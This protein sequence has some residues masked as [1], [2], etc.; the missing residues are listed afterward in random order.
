MAPESLLDGYFGPPSDLYALGVTLYRAVEGRPPFDSGEPLTEETLRSRT[1]RRPAHAD[2]LGAV[3]GGLLEQDPARRLDVA[4]ARS[5][6]QSVERL[7]SLT[8]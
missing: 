3:L 6:L 7:M 1:P 2:C 5:Q 4:G 8:V